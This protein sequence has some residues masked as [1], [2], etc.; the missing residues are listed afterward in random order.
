MMIILM[1]HSSSQS[2]ASALHISLSECKAFYLAIRTSSPS[3]AIF[4]HQDAIIP[5]IIIDILDAMGARFRAGFRCWLDFKKRGHNTAL[6]QCYLVIDDGECVGYGHQPRT[7]STD[8]APLYREYHIY[9][10]YWNKFDIAIQTSSNRRPRF[11]AGV[12]PSHE[13]GYRYFADA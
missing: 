12:P 2:T 7:P 1:T 13:I 11:I 3:H 5:F 10:T 6:Y 9:Q 8:V 4:P